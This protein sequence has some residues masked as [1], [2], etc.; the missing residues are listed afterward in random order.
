LLSHNAVGSPR[1]QGIVESLIGCAD[2]LF[3]RRLHSRVVEAGEISHP[4]IGGCR[5]HPGIAAIAECV[6]ESVIVLKQEE[7]LRIQ[8]GVYRIPVDRIRNIQV[9]VGYDGLTLLGHIRGRRE[10]LLLDVLQLADQ[11]LLRRATRT[12]I[13]LDGSGIDH[14]RERETRMFF[15]LRLEQLCSLIDCIVRA[16]PVD[17]YAINATT[18]HVFNLALGL[19]RV[20]GTV[21]NIHV[22]RLSEP[23]KQMGVNLG[24][25]ARVEERVDVNLAY[26]SRPKVA[27]CLRR[28]AIG[29]ARI[30]GGLRGKSCGGHN[31]RTGQCG[32]R[33]GEKR[34]RNSEYFRTHASS[35]TK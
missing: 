7:R 11:S 28:E 15:G 2:R 16:V 26:I 22:A 19:R 18:D 1:G 14:D 9:E 21:A 10:I 34:E 25:S 5:H 24:C 13:P 6:T 23:Q 32:D 27:V 4:V 3:A 35:T 17:D 12:G 33:R 20:V 8:G 30:V 31:V 29:R